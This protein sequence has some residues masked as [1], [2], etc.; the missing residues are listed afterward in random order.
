MAP[1]KRPSRSTLLAA[2]GVVLNN[3]MDDFT[4]KPGEPNLYGLIQSEANAI[5]PRKRPL[6]SMTP[7]L[8]ARGK[9]DARST[10]PE[11]VAALGTPGGPT[12][13]NQVFLMTLDLLVRQRDAQ[14]IV[15][16]PRFHHQWQPDKV[17]LEPVFFSA[18]ITNELENRGHSVVTR[19]SPMG[20]AHIIVADG[21]VLSAGADA[22]YSGA[23]VAVVLKSGALI[24]QE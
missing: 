16:L 2:I 15:S 9:A 24:G 23:A 14:S 22:R 10:N 11:I 3:E 20:A 17:F 13:I 7:T 8:I 12:I 5:A 6:S 18:D 4:S 19:S 1:H 21:K